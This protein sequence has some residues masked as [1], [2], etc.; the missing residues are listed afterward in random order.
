MDNFTCAEK[1]CDHPTAFTP[2]GSLDHK[3]KVLLAIVVAILALGVVTLIVQL[4][5]EYL[6]ERRARDE[7]PRGRTLVRASEAG[8]EPS[9][10][11]RTGEDL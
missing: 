9:N 4:I 11:G 2:Q 8:T 1:I 7:P 3:Y 6:S 10:L 5:M